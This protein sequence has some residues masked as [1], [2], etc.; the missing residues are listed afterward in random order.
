MIKNT[1][2]IIL[3]SKKH[4]V[5]FFLLVSGFVFAQDFEFTAALSKN[6]LGVNQRFKIE[7]SINKNGADNFKAPDFSNF[8]VVAGPSSSVSQ[9][10]VNGKS[11][12]S[13]SYIYILEPK[14]VGK[15]TISPAQIEYKGKIIHA[16]AVTINVSEKVAIPKNPNDPN[17]IAQENIHLV[18]FVS[19]SSPYVGESVFVE[20]RLYF[21]KKVGFS[22]PQFGENPKYE[23]FWNQEIPIKNNQEKNG[24]FNGKT[25]RY[26]TIKK[27]VLI[28]QKSGKLYVNPMAMD[29]AVSVP[30]GRYD[31]FGNAQTRRIS[32]HYASNKRLIRVKPLPI[33][34]KPV[35][36]TGAVGNYNLDVSASKISLKA[37]ESTQIQVKITGEGNLKL[38][39]IPKLVVPA[40]LEVYTPEN[41][42]KVRTTLRGLKGNITDSYSIVPEYKGKYKIPVLNFSYFNPKDK[43]YHS[44]TSKELI[45]EVTEGKELPSTTND[46]TSQ[47][48]FVK[49]TGGNFR[50]IRTQTEFISGNTFEFYNSKW[51]YGLLSLFLLT[52]PVGVFIGRKRKKMMGDIAGNKKRAADKLARKYLSEAK[53]QINNKEAFYIALE[54]ALHNFLKAKLSIETSDISQEKIG[55]LLKKHQTSDQTIVQLNEVLDAC[56][57][58]RYTPTTNLKMQGV[59]KKA[60]GVLSK[61]N[62]EIKAYKN[63]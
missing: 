28:P 18:A 4:I 23:G 11:S 59:Y 41:K 61:I 13:Q 58:G 12:Y 7:F 24:D 52:I 6:V 2:C 50:F 40:E 19:N 9:S 46:E 29:M 21:S 63:T 26:Y 48:Q 35:D 10:W 27:T 15:F 3:F 25:Y 44:L 14:V 36:F 30:T 56:N 34:G 5:L 55:E 33:E 32:A 42:Q 57:F 62:S 17:Y 53:K 51:Y 49:N 16:N 31:F 60:S 47:K 38:F 54:K 20:Y 1:K 37:N 8:K 43:Q 39:E 45:I 22:S